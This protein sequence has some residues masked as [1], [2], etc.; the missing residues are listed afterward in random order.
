MLKFIN[1]RR[2][3][4]KWLDKPV[5]NQDVQDIIEAGMNAPSAGNEQAWQMILLT[6]KDILNTISEF[7]QNIS[8]IKNA[9]VA[10]MVC[11]DLQAQKYQGYYV[12]DCSAATE[13]ML[14]AIHAKGLG[15]F[16]G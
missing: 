11:G 15:G 3:V 9:A 7:N 6:D 5:N 16:W 14:L 1:T 2:S 10:I 8:I 4:R 13:N 12:H